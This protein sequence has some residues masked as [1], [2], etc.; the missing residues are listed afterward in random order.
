[1]KWDKKKT[2]K[3]KNLYR[4]GVPIQKITDKLNKS[5]G[6]IEGKLRKLGIIRN[7]F[8][9]KLRMPS[10]IT[11]AL[12]RIHAHVC[13]DGN[14][15]RSSEKDSYGY[16]GRYKFNRRRYRYGIGYTNYNQR[17][18]KEFIE[19]VKLT[20]NLKPYYRDNFVRVKSRD[21]WI[22]LKELG[23]DKSRDWFVSHKI[24]KASKVIKKNWIRAFFDD[25]A[26]FNA[27]GRIRVR[28]VNRNGLIQVTE[29][30]KEF[31]PSHITPKKDYYPDHSVYLNINKS[32]AGKYFS[33]I[34]SLRY[35]HNSN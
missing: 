28:S 21:V 19:D 16:L 18:I 26:C 24:I 14:L 11:P 31:V 32:D 34:G 2:L 22:L 12:A 5:A 9:P 23:A 4:G 1:M 8:I 25:E 20:F 7:R 27:G 35:R 30:L 6:A 17:L 15:F 33:K 10:R 13:G 3:L 29:M